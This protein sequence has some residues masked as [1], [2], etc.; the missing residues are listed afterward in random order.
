MLTFI[1]FGKCR[2]DKIEEVKAAIQK[3]MSTIEDESGTP[4]YVVYQGRD[5]P[6]RIVFY[7][8]YQ[9]QAAKDEHNKNPALKEMMD[10]IWPA[11]EGEVITGFYET[12]VQK[13]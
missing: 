11:F 1:G 6:N 5:D 9:D 13:K 3:F 7:E 10:V 4:V 8:Q 12:L 2:S